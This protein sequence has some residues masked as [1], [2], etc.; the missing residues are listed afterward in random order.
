MRNTSF[1][2]VLSTKTKQPEFFCLVFEK[3]GT[4]KG[5]VTLMMM[6]SLWIFGVFANL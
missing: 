6:M 4:L 3:N 5:V 1:K 2:N